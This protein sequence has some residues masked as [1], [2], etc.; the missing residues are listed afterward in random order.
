M[1]RQ[2]IL[3][4]LSARELTETVASRMVDELTQEAESM[5]DS[6]SDYDIDSFSDKLDDFSMDVQRAI[7]KSLSE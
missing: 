3:D 2:D 6:L 4:S 1:Q 5:G 7:E